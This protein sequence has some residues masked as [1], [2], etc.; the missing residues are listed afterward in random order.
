MRQLV[1]R[2]QRKL[3]IAGQAWELDYTRGE[4]IGLFYPRAPW[5]A[6]NAPEMLRLLS[7]TRTRLQE[8]LGIAADGDLTCVVAEPDWVEEALGVSGLALGDV[9]IVACRPRCLSDFAGTAAHELAHV[10]SRS[11]GLWETPFKAPVMPP[12]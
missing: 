10:L 6:E 3:R 2:L 12:R 7:D 11:V 4:G 5:C 8:G 9:I 1:D